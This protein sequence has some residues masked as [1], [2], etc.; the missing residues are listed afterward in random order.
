MRRQSKD[1]VSDAAGA[2]KHGGK[3][4]SCNYGETRPPYPH[5]LMFKTIE[6]GDAVVGLIGQRTGAWKLEG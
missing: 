4:F 1:A 2:E 6:A 5:E 3:R